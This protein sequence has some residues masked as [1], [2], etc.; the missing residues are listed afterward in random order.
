MSPKCLFEVLSA[1]S[2]VIDLVLKI[3]VLRILQDGRSRFGRWFGVEK[4]TTASG[5]S[6]RLE[7]SIRYDARGRSV[8]V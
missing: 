6:L 2:S 1:K 8:C 4:K 5:W 3:Q 7:G